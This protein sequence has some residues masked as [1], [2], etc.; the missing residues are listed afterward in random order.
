MSYYL[1]ST[2]LSWIKKIFISSDLFEIAC[3]LF[4]PLKYLGEK[5]I[6]CNLHKDDL[7]VFIKNRSYS[8]I[9]EIFFT[10][11]SINYRKWDKNTIF[12]DQIIWLN[13]CI[14]INR[15]PLFNRKCIEKGIMKV[16][17]LM[18]DGLMVITYEEFLTQY[19]N[20]INFVEF[21]GI[22]NIT[23]DG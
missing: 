22:Y 19:G 5:A 13:S 9:Y 10:L 4:H 15:K 17:D 23:R 1:E 6:V 21:N 20:I 18:I 16:S 12:S 7:N 2:K 3:V 14:K 11:Y 8:I